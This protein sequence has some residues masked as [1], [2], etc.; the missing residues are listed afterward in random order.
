MFESDEKLEKAIIEDKARGIT[1]KEIGKKYRVTL[2]VIEK[3]ITRRKGIN[4][5]SINKRKRIKYLEPP[6][7]SLQQGSVW[8]FKQ[9]GNWATHS[10]EYRGNYSPYIPRNI[11]LRYSN[12]G[13]L[14]LDMFCGGGTTAIECKLLGRRCKASDINEKAIE[15]ARE[16]LDFNFNPLQFP[17][18]PIKEIFD[19][20]LY[21]KDARD[22]SWI[23]DETI[24]LICTHPPYANIIQYT[25]NKA[26]DLSFLDIEDFLKEMQKVAAESFRVLKPGRQCALLIGDTRRK[27]HVVPI[28]FWLIDVYLKTGF[29]LRELIIKR[30]HNCKTTGFWYDKSIKNNFLLLA[31]EYLPV[32]EKPYGKNKRR[33]IAEQ[34]SSLNLKKVHVPK[35]DI[36]RSLETTTVWV[37]P[38]DRRDQLLSQNLIKRYASDDGYRKIAINKQLECGESKELRFKKDR[39]KLI[40]IDSPALAGGLNFEI[41]EY[42]EAVAKVVKQG[43]DLLET[44][45]FIAIETRDVRYNGK[46]IPFAK[47][48]IELLK[49]EPLWLKEIIIV[50]SENEKPNFNKIENYNRN[51]SEYL[52]SEYLQI[53]HS[54]LLIYEK[55]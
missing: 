16:N 47:R 25:D 50:T 26:A 21:V 4:I 42:L 31:H 18:L 12:P 19:P 5:S 35:K 23:K 33:K 22:L 24:D 44:E 52:V 17:D 14:V 1:D 11:I 9:R 55:N 37:F 38:D 28:G 30:Q 45:G 10:G 49:N 40:W 41:G 15:L 36:A 43:I 39:C 54:Y 27:R 3:I 29:E 7:F 13:E 46:I 48:I 8:S 51:N 34:K 20:E 6:E 2:R 53:N 32:F